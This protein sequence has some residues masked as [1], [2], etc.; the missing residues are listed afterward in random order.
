MR[1]LSGGIVFLCGTGA[2]LAGCLHDEQAPT[3]ATPA[4]GPTA[5][6]PPP[7]GTE[8]TPTAPPTPGPM[9]DP[10]ALTPDAKPSPLSDP[11]PIPE[12]WLTFS[13]P[14]GKATAAFTLRLP[15]GWIAPRPIPSDIVAASNVLGWTFTSW[16]PEQPTRDIERPPD[17]SIK[18]DLSAQRTGSGSID[19][20]LPTNARTTLAGLQ[21]E[22]GVSRPAPGSALNV[23]AAYSFKLAT[24]GFDY[25][26]SAI[27]TGSGSPAFL[28]QTLSQILNSWSIKP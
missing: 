3:P 13:Q 4:G 1:G 20:L 23:D 11:M 26:L 5:T 7:P 25:C 10:Y 2:L 18:I 15:P 28:E 27:I 19:C 12:S 21:A 16:D 22:Y 6:L 14:A 17:A 9:G 24:G 8:A